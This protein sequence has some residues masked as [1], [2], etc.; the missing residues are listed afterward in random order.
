MPPAIQT[1]QKLIP[2][3]PIRAPIATSAPQAGINSEMKASDSPNA[4]KSTIGAAQAEWSRTK[5]ASARAQ[6]SRTD[7][8]SRHQ[9][10]PRTS[11]VPIATGNWYA[12]PFPDIKS[13]GADAGFTG[14][15]A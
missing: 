1:G 10:G 8:P 14:F 15:G 13:Q 4:S 2:L 3:A 12:S 7:R 5:S 9:S 11:G 6:P